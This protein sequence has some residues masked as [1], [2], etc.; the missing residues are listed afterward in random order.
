[1]FSIVVCGMFCLRG[2]LIRFSPGV[3]FGH[4]PL[5]H[6][7]VLSFGKSRHLMEESNLIPN[8]FSWALQLLVA[9]LQSSLQG[10]TGFR[11]P[12]QGGAKTEHTKGPISGEHPLSMSGLNLLVAIAVLASSWVWW[13]RRFGNWPIVYGM[14]WQ[15]GMVICS[16]LAVNKKDIIIL[17]NIWIM[18]FW[19]A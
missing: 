13:L 7:D 1:M 18:Q 12:L 19:L 5:K 14:F 8:F 3:F 17:L 16:Q 10:T 11:V 4:D 2:A 6:F 9:R 15:N